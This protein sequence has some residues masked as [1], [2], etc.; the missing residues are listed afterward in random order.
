MT[1]RM[2]GLWLALAAFAAS[3][4][5]YTWTGA[6]SALWS[7]TA[8]WS[9]APT[10]DNTADVI[11]YSTGAGNLNTALGSAAVTIRSLTFNDNAD[12]AV[13]VSL[14]N[15]GGTARNLQMSADSG[16]ASITV[17]ASATGDFTIGTNGITTGQG[18]LVLQSNLDIVLESQDFR[19]MRLIVGPRPGLGQAARG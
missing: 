11:Y 8:N 13:F 15:N 18:S 2:I 9:P 7:N 16:N 5:T 3:A 10:F 12:A 17:D 14:N 4:G 6:S 1:K 19:L